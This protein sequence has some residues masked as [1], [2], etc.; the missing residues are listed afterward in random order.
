[1]HYS[2]AGY[3]LRR[4]RLINMFSVYL[5]FVLMYGPRTGIT[6]GA[7][8]ICQNFKFSTTHL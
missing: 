7:M 3:S 8:I 1:M 2:L 4:D 6:L 5:I